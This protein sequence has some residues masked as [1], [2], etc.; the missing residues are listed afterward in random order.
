MF[1]VVP[2]QL[3]IS[4]GWV[5]CGQCGEIF[6][7]S[8]NLVAGEPAREWAPP[9]PTPTPTPK[10]TPK[11]VAPAPAPAPG[12]PPEAGGAGAAMVERQDF[13]QKV[14][15]LE[16]APGDPLPRRPTSD[17]S[18]RAAAAHA[19]DTQ[20]PD[21]QA[22]APP[23]YVPVEPFWAQEPH[24][25]DTRAITADAVPLADAH[26]ASAEPAPVTN[27]HASTR[28][29]DD[30]PQEPALSFMQQDRGS[31]F[32]GRL[33]VRLA[34]VALALMLTVVL[35][36]QVLVQERNRL[37]LLEPASRPA[38]QALCRLARCEIGALRQI[39][40]VVID[41]SSFG[42][43]RGDAYRLA[44]SLRNQAPIDI[45]MPAIELSLT[46]TQDQALIRRVILPSEYGAPG[47]VLAAGADWSGTLAMNIRP[48]AGTERIA[49]YRLLAFYP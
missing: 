37:V 31:H 35:A 27:A 49:G 30:A 25:P 19:P 20:A 10:P 34:L 26:G 9:T 18:A 3:R 13:E 32:W 11:P 21:T 4:E 5:R 28:D 16:P 36:A 46:D 22:P 38:I 47:A 2:D 39:E 8:Q 15:D 12:Q 7:A 45:A 24:A 41:S 44:F 43:L 42:R 29:T 1:K 14:W 48:G 6:N 17:P 33:P 23:P 40:S